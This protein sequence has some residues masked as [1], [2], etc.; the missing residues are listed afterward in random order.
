MNDPKQRTSLVTGANTGIGRVTATE[1]ARRGDR[2]ILAC[3]SAERT[4]PVI[5]EITAET[6][7]D[8]VEFVA[9]DLEDL[10]AVRASVDTLVARGDTIDVLVAN[11]GLAGRRGVTAQGF[12]MAFGTNHVGHFAFVNGVLPLVRSSGAEPARIVVV[13]SD[14][15]YGAKGIDFDA[16]R[17]PTK[18]VTGMP[19][20]QVSKLANVC[21][22]EEL[23]RRVDA[24]DVF[25][26]AVHPGVIA[27]DIWRRLPW[28]I[29]PLARRFMK[30]PADGARTSLQCANDP[31]VL[32]HHGA[33][34]SEGALK[35]PSTV[36]TPE[37]AAE[38]WR[39][40]EEWTAG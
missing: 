12:E 18:S 17:R 35:E 40:S 7:N 22:A 39:R 16:V 20:Y 36:V 9:L 21:F 28:P 6:G 30:S 11:A 10:D 5:D 1:L 34:Y 27:T 15:H 33:Y 8:A 32:A 29:R 2:V 25:V 4:L 19:E 23:A 24:D 14:A 3:R 26:C 31:D 37:L 13:A 38:L